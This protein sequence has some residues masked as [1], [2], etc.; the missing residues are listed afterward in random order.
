MGPSIASM[1]V[2][3]LEE[4]MFAQY[5]LTN[6]ESLF[7]CYTR[8]ILMTLLALLPVLVRN[9]K[10]LLTLSPIS[11]HPS[12]SPMSSPTLLLLPSWI[13]NFLCVRNLSNRTS[14]SRT[15]TLTVISCI[16]PAIHPRVRTPFPSPSCCVP[17]AYVLM[18]RTLL[19]SL[20]KSRTSSWNE[21]ILRMS[22]K[23]PMIVWRMSTDLPLFNHLNP[24]NQIA[25][26]S[27]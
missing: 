22:T 13:F 17:D 23:L 5:N 12:N 2:G 15:L 10:L 16:L 20:K 27:L 1:F 8:G 18:M 7:P 11:I 3:Y 24:D 25:F 26:H 21:N 14:T 4:L 19:R 6:S 9:S